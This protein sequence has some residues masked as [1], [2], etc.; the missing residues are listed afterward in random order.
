VPVYRAEYL[1]LDGCREIVDTFRA[2]DD[3]EAIEL[4]R[5]RLEPVDCDLWCHTRK[6]ATVP[7]EGGL[8]ILSNLLLASA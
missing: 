3:G 6:V 7:A 1:S 8:P 5:L 2:A 4:L